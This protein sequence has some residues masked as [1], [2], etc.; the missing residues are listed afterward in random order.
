LGSLERRSCKVFEARALAPVH[1]VISSWNIQSGEPRKL[2]CE[3]AR[4]RRRAEHIGN[5]LH[6]FASPRTVQHGTQK[7]SATNT[8]Y[9]TAPY[10]DC[11]SLRL[12]CATLTFE[13]GNSIGALWVGLIALSVKA[14][15]LSVEDIVGR[16]RN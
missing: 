2:S 5:R 13:F 9:V 1:D 3:I 12:L 4:V 15:L 16:E 6:S 14:F 10:D 8:E 7:V 11:A